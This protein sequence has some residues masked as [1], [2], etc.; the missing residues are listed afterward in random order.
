MIVHTLHMGVSFT[1]R[2]SNVHGS[3]SRI[4]GK[5]RDHGEPSS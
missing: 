1:I 5:P 3:T 4:L 2:L